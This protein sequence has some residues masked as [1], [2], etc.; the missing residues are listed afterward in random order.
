VHFRTDFPHTDPQQAEHI[1]I[2]AAANPRTDAI[3]KR[4]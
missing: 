2:A 1:A 3:T 4:R